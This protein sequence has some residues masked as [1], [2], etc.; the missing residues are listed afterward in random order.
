[1]LQMLYEFNIM[2]TSLP[3]IN[4]PKMM[5]EYILETTST[6]LSFR[7]PECPRKRRLIGINVTFKYTISGDDWIWFAKIK[8]TNHVEIIYNPKVFGKPE[9]GKIAIWL[10]YWPIGNKLNDHDIVNVSIIVMNGLE[11][12]EC[13]ASLV[14]TN[15]EV[16][17]EIF[18]NNNGLVETDGGDLLGFKLSTGAYYLCRRDFFMLMELGRLTP[19]WLST[20]VSHTD[21]VEDTG[22]FL[23][24]NYFWMF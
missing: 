6:S 13:G 14:Y 23:L 8:T 15:D 20:L 11:I 3:D 10:S 19:G 24:S 21:A 5:P 9:P 16:A 2:S 17:N 1:M 18:E 22:M 4:I 7:V 12:Q